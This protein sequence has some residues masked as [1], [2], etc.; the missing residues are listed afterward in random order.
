MDAQSRRREFHFQIL[1]RTLEH[2]GS[3]MYKRRDTAIAELVAN[4][5]D[6]GATQAHVTV[7]DPGTY[8]SLTDNIVISDDGSGMS[9]ESVQDDYLVVGRNRRAEGQPEPE[10]RKV[11]GRKG[12]GKLAGFG[13][14]GKMTL[15]TWRDG[16]LTT[17][18]LELGRLKTKAG[19]ATDVTL[20]GTVGSAA[21]QPYASG[22]TLTLTSLKHKTGVS[23][24][25]LRES[26]S[27]RFSYTVRGRM[28]VYVNGIEVVDPDINLETRFPA[29]TK[30]EPTAL[31][32]AQLEDGTIARYWYG[33]SKTVLASSRMRGFAI[34]VN[35]KT[36][37]A[38][39]F[40][41]FVEGT[42]SGQHGTRYLTGV[43]EADFLDAGTDDESDIVSTD[44]QELD[45]DDERTNAL[46]TWGDRKTRELL[47]EWANRRAAAVKKFV[48][49]D[50]VLKTR[51]EKLDER[52][53]KQVDKLLYTLG[54]A[55]ADQSRWKEMAGQLIAAYEYRHF[56]E[57]IAE[58]DNLGDDP[59][60]LVSLLDHLRTWRTLESRAILAVVEGRLQIVEKFYSMLV[61]N[62][63]ETAGRI[64]DENLHD[65][66]A[67][68]PWLLHPD[69]QALS[70]ERRITSQ[71][72]E[73]NAADV[74]EDDR[75]RYDFLALSEPGHL[76]VVEIKRSG[77]PPTEEELQR[78]LRYRTKLSKGTKAP[79]TAV[80]V[81]SDQFADDVTEYR[82]MANLA[83]WTWGEVHDRVSRLYTHYGAV[84]RDEN[85]EGD[86]DD[87][88]REV[89][90]TRR[91]LEQG[92]YRG[93]AARAEGLGPQDI[94]YGGVP[95]TEPS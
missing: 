1:G 40:F 91:V 73:W 25:D 78:L 51:I 59:E 57:M 63:P 10:G 2:L 77:H 67:Q 24:S 15:D 68:Y 5:W 27:R 89:Q 7:P 18:P 44:R 16:V 11:M 6:A 30:D 29:P 90:L 92:V 50:P 60:A 36:A 34:L 49:D 72:K 70:E 14:A 48:V 35:G 61:G 87:K 4:A 37:Q 22:T 95:N 28:T 42:A 31:A 32:E 93:H 13:I 9:E 64:G 19:Q 82:K 79:I 58:L 83:F 8:N 54:Q 75:T 21:N 53:Q 43:I 56:H 80:F 12:I 94:D 17:V 81:S 45:W 69:W 26:L 39:P 46:R 20:D 41:F 76:V 85:N 86:W 47:R 62:A 65:L 66:I 52:S 23:P 3:Q 84:L 74:D 33:F 88:Q 38:P 71:L 55:D